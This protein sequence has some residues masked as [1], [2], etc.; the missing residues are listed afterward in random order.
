M[1]DL[2][3][4]KIFDEFFDGIIKVNILLKKFYFLGCKSFI[5]YGIYFFLEVYLFFEL[6]VFNDIEIFIDE[7]VIFIC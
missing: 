7:F 5:F 1:I 6:L 4:V 3:L 2:N